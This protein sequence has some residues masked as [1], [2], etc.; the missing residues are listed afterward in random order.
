FVVESEPIPMNDFTLQRYRALL[1]LRGEV[2]AAEGDL[3]L[4]EHFFRL[5]R[6]MQ[7]L[8][9]LPGVM[10]VGAKRHRLFDLGDRRQPKV[11]PRFLLRHVAGE[12]FYMQ[13]LH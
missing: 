7:Y 6:L 13:P 10:F 4:V 3:E 2:E 1:V 8:S 11:P 9:S 12:I 5:A